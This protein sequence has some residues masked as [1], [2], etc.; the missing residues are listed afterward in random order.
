M[1]SDINAV[2]YHETV[3]TKYHKGVY[4]TCFRILKWKDFT[5]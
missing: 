5:A 3:E 2:S 1:R 4:R